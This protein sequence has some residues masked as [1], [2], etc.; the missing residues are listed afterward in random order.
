MIYLGSKGLF[1]TSHGLNLAYLSGLDET[2]KQYE[3]DD[4]VKFNSKDIESLEVNCLK[5][6]ESNN[7]IIDILLTNQWPKYIERLQETTKS[8]VNLQ[9]IAT[10][11]CGSDLISH[12]AMK[13][14]PRY[15]F[16]SQQRNIYFE[17]TPYRNHTVLKEKSIHLTRFLGL[18][19][20]NTSNKPKVN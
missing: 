12:L 3:S 5:K 6:L 18:A 19:K 1:T 16:T 15:H 9:E 13:I 8:D 20:V 10:D 2:N 17:R 14:K 4:F 7:Q 11:K